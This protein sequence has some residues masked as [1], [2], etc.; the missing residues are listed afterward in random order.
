[1]RVFRPRI[2]WGEV[3]RKLRALRNCRGETL[4]MPL[5]FFGKPALWRDALK[6]SYLCAAECWRPLRRARRSGLAA[7]YFDC[8]QGV[9]V[10]IGVFADA[11][12]GALHRRLCTGDY[13]FT[14]STMRLHGF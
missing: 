1:M 8:H 11:V 4:I 5:D 3:S 9:I 10:E 6:G 13:T 12:L 2:F 7:R 14:P